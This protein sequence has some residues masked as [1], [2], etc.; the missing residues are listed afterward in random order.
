MISP[1]G[2][3]M[4]FSL[5]KLKWKNKIELVTHTWPQPGVLPVHQ[6]RPLVPCQ[7]A[8]RRSHG[9]R[10][11]QTHRGAHQARNYFWTKFFKVDVSLKL[12]WGFPFL[13]K[14][15]GFV[16]SLFISVSVVPLQQTS[17]K[18]LVGL[19]V[20]Y[21]LQKSWLLTDVMY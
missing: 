2:K 5:Q 7:R 16:T 12:W 19:W 21:T 10:V 9:Q 11:G 6:E 8:V 1:P 3:S 13:S 17:H 18:L 20:I 14:Q 15:S 4:N